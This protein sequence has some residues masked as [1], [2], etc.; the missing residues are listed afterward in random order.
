MSENFILLC[1]MAAV[2]LPVLQNGRQASCLLLRL[3]LV[4]AALAPVW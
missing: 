3:R 2:P 4:Q 1:K